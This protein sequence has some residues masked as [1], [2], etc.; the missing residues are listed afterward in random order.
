MQLTEA[1]RLL[2]PAPMVLETGYERLPACVLHIACR[3]RSC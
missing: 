3:Q 1:D 2:D